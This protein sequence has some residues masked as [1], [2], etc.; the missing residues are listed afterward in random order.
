VVKDVVALNKKLISRS[1]RQLLCL[2][3]LAEYLECSE[4]DLRERI[5]EFRES[6]CA[7]FS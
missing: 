6:G 5:K 3:C 1:G 7:L 4:D 2:T